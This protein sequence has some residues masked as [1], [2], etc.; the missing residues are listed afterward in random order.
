MWSN[1]GTQKSQ[2]LMDQLLAGFFSEGRCAHHPHGAF[3]KLVALQY[4]S[5]L[6]GQN[7]KGCA[8]EPVLDR[9]VSLTHLFCAKCDIHIWFEFVDS[10][11]NWR[12]GRSP[13]FS[14]VG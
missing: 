12:D 2:D 10:G 3:V 13:R 9:C 4:Q 7:L 11:S 5:V 6:H 8:R 1:R 14:S